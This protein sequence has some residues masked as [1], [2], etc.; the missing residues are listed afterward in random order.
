MTLWFVASGLAGEINQRCQWVPRGDEP[1]R[2]PAVRVE[3]AISMMS[4]PLLLQVSENGKDFPMSLLLIRYLHVHVFLRRRV[5]IVAGLFG[6]FVPADCCMSRTVQRC[7]GS[8]GWARK[9]TQWC[10]LKG[11]KEKVQSSPK[12]AT[13]KHSVIWSLVFVLPEINPIIIMWSPSQLIWQKFSISWSL[14]IIQMW[15]SLPRT[16]SSCS[17]MPNRSTR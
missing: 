3:G 17:K 10:F 11:T 14:R 16:S 4:P 9:A 6:V 2:L 1:L 5:N 15:S 13:F 12:G 7:Q 8:Q